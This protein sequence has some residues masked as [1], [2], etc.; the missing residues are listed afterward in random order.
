[1]NSV[2]WQKINSQCDKE[3][4]IFGRFYANQAQKPS[5]RQAFS[6]GKY[7]LSKYRVIKL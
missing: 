1:M 3:K 7:R 2:E 6:G 5:F 4:F